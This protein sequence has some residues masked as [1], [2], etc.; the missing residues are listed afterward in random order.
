M[1]TN[2]RR[3]DLYMDHWQHY[4]PGWAA[5]TLQWL[6]RPS[7]RWIRIP[8]GLLLVLAGLLSFLP[9]FGLWMLV[10]GL[11]LLSLDLP[12]LRRPIRVAILRV[13]RWRHRR[14]LRRRSRAG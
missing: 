9:V 5:P 4:L 6:R 1:D 14:Q 2:K 3:L 8:M 10:P 7:A 12:V 11:L 13:R